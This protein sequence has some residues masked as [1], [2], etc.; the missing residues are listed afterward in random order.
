[1]KLKSLDSV[2]LDTILRCTVK[3]DE[4]LEEVFRIMVQLTKE[5]NLEQ[6][7]LSVFNSLG[8]P[9]N[10]IPSPTTTNNIIVNLIQKTGEVSS[11]G[12]I[13][14]HGGIDQGDK[15]NLAIGDGASINFAEARAGADE[16]LSVIKEEM[17]NQNQDLIDCVKVLTNAIEAKDKMKASDNLEKI[18]K[19][20]GVG[21]K[22]LGLIKT[23][24]GFLV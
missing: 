24:S 15:S 1:M 8:F 14:I 17:G 21:S 10:H 13:N 19:T 4:Q 5:R 12:G 20:I 3:E 9:M 22:A 18:E 7:L 16:L 11:M 2:A 23:I 6:K